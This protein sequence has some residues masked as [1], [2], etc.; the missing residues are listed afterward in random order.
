MAVAVAAVAALLVVAE[1]VCAVRV[2]AADE[3]LELPFWLRLPLALFWR[4]LLALPLR[5]PPPP[6]ALPP[7]E[8][9][10]VGNSSR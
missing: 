6:L 4:L 5:L 8:V 10:G 7:I 3:V 2:L 1:G 9:V